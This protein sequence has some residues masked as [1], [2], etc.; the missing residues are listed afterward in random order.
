MPGMEVRLAAD[1]E[2]EVRGP[3]VFPGYLQADG[4]VEPAT[5]A[6]GWLP[7]G[8][9]GTLDDDGFLRITDRK[10]ELIITA[11]GK[12]I[13]PSKVESLLRAHPLVGYADVIDELYAGGRA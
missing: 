2:I 7:T 1:G 8:D 11:S 13:A 12:N 6:D 10:K 3:L 9:I 4:H 5:D